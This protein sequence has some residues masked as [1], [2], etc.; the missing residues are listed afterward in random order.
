MEET[1]P[2]LQ[3]LVEQAIEI[4][5]EIQ[6]HPDHQQ[7]IDDG[8]QPDVTIFDAMNALYELDKELE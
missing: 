3:R 5:G 2:C 4:I 7:L 8:Y 1:L 6:V